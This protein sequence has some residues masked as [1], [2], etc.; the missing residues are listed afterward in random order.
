MSRYVSLSS[1]L[2]KKCTSFGTPTMKLSFGAWMVCHSKVSLV[3]VRTRS[4][5]N[6][7][8]DSLHMINL[9]CFSWKRCKIWLHIDSS[10]TGRRRDSILCGN[11]L[12]WHVWCWER[13]NWTSRPQSVLQLEWAGKKNGLRCVYTHALLMVSS[14]VGLGSTQQTS[15]ESSLWLSGDSGNGERLG[16]RLVTGISSNVYSESDREYVYTWGRSRHLSLSWYRNGIPISKERGFSTWNICTWSLS[17][18]LARTWNE[19]QPLID[20]SLYA[21]VLVRHI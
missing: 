11:G 18:R 16:K 2:V 15:M 14:L 3:E 19:E 8:C 20:P 21:S 13:P 12:Q 4:Q 10:C 5:V 17:Y 7:L 1:L 9:P 6:A